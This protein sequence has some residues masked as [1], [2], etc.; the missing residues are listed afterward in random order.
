MQLAKKTT[1][2]KKE[3]KYV[4]VK[5]AIVALEWSSDVDFDLIVLYKTKDGREGGVWSN[6]F[7]G[8]PANS[9]GD[10]NEFPFIQLSGDMGIGRAGGD[11]IE[12]M[13]VAKLDDMAE[14]H[15]LA[16]NFSDYAEGTK[17]TF[18]QYNGKVTLKQDNGEGFEC[19]L[20]AT[21]AGTVAHIA[22]ISAGMM[23]AKLTRVDKVLSYDDAFGS[24]PGGRG[25]PSTCVS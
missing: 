12:T 22:T 14:V 7:R 23:G 20:E 18:S 9:L 3:D 8:A 24:L 16:F 21:E 11:N 4:E 19:P 10:L 1:L 15:I 25:F 13:R 6:A 5:Q 17:G 2:S